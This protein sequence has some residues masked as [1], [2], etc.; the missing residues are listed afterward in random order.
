MKLTK[1]KARL[2]QKAVETWRDDGVLSGAESKRLMDHLE[3]IAF[4]WK[5]LARYCFWAAIA[6]IFIS[7]SSVLMDQQLMELLEFLFNMPPA[8]KCV[9]L[10]M[11]AAGAYYLGAKRRV[12]NPQNLFSNEAVFF[13]GV[14]AT[15]GSIAYLGKAIDNG[16]G[17]FSLLILLACLVYGILGIFLDSRLIWVF[18]VLSLGGWFGTET[19]Y[20]SGWGAYYL[21]MNYPLRFVFFGLGLTLASY[22][23]LKSPHWKPFFSSTHKLGM[24][25]LFIA[26]WILSIF[27]NYGDW[28]VWHHVKQYTLFGWSVLFGLAAAAALYHGLKYDNAASRGFGITFLGINLYTRFFEYFWDSLHKAIFFALLGLSLWWLGTE[29]ENI[30]L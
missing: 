19:G 23:F 24:L 5:R 27:G 18:A 15:A 2:I 16:S 22:L 30:W 8:A 12:Q 7:V 25:Y 4:D 9:F 11:A 21:G 17:H 14:L 13:L 3:I 20:E 26:L 10:A 28:N 6:C 29:A 1:G